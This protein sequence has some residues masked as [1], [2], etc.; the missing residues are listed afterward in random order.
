[1]DAKNGLKDGLLFLGLGEK[2]GLI[3]RELLGDSSVLNKKKDAI[4][5]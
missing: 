1:M 4:Y 5:E 2:L 3:K